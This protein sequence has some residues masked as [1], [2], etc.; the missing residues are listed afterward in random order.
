MVVGHL[1]GLIHIA[2]FSPSYSPVPLGCTILIA[3]KVRRV[4][5]YDFQKELHAW[6]QLEWFCSPKFGLF[7]RPGQF[8]IRTVSW[9]FFVYIW[10]V[11]KCRG[12]RYLARSPRKHGE[13]PELWPNWSDHWPHRTELGI[14]MFDPTNFLDT[15]L[16]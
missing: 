1:T 7:P 11:G 8:L 13:R 12:A 5:H 14:L 6:H 2:Q 16:S 10:N 15:L 9:M 3:T 4:N